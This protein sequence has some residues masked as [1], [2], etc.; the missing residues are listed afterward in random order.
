MSPSELKARVDSIIEAQRTAMDT[1]GMTLAA[2]RPGARLAYFVA[3]VDKKAELE[4]S[5]EEVRDAFRSVT[6]MLTDSKAYNI[7]PLAFE[8]L[9][10]DGSVLSSKQPGDNGRRVVEAL[11]TSLVMSFLESLID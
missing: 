2:M 3:P 8:F 5:L 9:G 4:E 7:A 11:S 1:Y 10:I 6:R